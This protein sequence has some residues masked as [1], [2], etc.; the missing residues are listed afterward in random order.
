MVVLTQNNFIA[1]ERLDLEDMTLLLSSSQLDFQFLLNGLMSA[2][3]YIVNGF[4]VASTLGNTNTVQI[5]GASSTLLKANNIGNDPFSFLSL[6]PGTPN[7]TASL[8]ASSRNYVELR[9]TTVQGTP[10]TRNFWDPTANNGLGAEF[11]QEVNTV[12]NLEAVLDIT[13]SGF[14]NDASHIP[15]AIVDTDNTNTIKAIFDARNLFFRLGQFNNEGRNFAWSSQNEPS[16]AVVLSSV[17]GTFVAGE[18]VTFKVGLTTE[19]TATVFSWTP[20]TSTLQIFNLSL[21][22]LSSPIVGDSVTGGT[23][24]ATGTV[25][26]ALDSFTGADKDIANFAE[27]ISALQTEIKAIKG[28]PQWFNVAPASLTSLYNMVVALENFLDGIIVA[29]PADTSVPAPN[30]AWDGAN[31]S[32]TDGSLTPSSAD[33]IA[34]IRVFGVSEVL[35]LARQDGTGGSAVIPVGADQVLFVTLPSPSGNVTYSGVGAGATNYQVVNRTAYVANSQNFWLA[36]SN[37]TTLYVRGYGAIKT[38]Q[39]VQLTEGPTTGGSGTGTGVGDDLGTL[40]YLASFSDL[41]PTP[42]TVAGPINISAGFTNPANYNAAF[43]YWTLNYDASKTLTGTG[44]DMNLSASASYTVVAGDVIRFSNQVRRI[45][46]VISQSHFTIESAFSANPTSAACTVSQAVYTVDIDNYADAGISIQAALGG[47]VNQ[48]LMD[49]DD[50][51]TSGSTVISENVTPFVAYVASSDNSSFSN[52][53]TRT[54]HITDEDTSL[55]LPTTSAG[56]YLRFFANPTSGSGFV[57]LLRYKVFLHSQQP[58]TATGFA[59][60][61]AAFFTD[62]SGTQINCQPPTV[63]GGKTQ[64]QL[65]FTYTPGINSGSENGQLLVTINGQKIPRF[66]SGAT[67]D[68]YYTEVDNET[69]R[70]DSDYS[71]YN[72]NVEVIRWVASVDVN[73]QNQA[74]IALIEASK[75]RNYLINSNF[76]YNQ[77]AGLSGSYSTPTSGAYNLDR[78]N[79]QY[80]GTPGTFSINQPSFTLGQGIVPDEP[81]YYWQLAQTVANSGSTLELLSQKIESVR[82]LANKTV[83]LSFWASADTARTLTIDFRQFFGT[84]GGPSSPVVTPGASFG[85]TTGFQQ[86]SITVSLPSLSGKALGTNGDDYLE[87]RFKTPLNTTKTINISHVMLNEGNGIL[88]WIS[89]GKE[90][91]AELALCQRFY[92]KSWDIDVAVGTGSL[93]TGFSIGLSTPQFGVLGG[94]P[95]V[96]YDEVY[97]VVKRVDAIPHSYSATSGTIDTYRDGSASSDKTATY[98][99]ISQRGFAE[100][101]LSSQNPDSEIYYQWTADAEITS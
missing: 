34:L 40:L 88:P 43:T 11:L 54:V 19:A 36:Y 91:E 31:V 81:T 10:L 84:G 89:A 64:V 63:V 9:L 48:I 41:F 13:T 23:S 29:N 55:A 7:L 80:D 49:Y 44:T 65:G 5:A 98:A 17:V 15:L 32:I 72:F 73:P 3:A 71:A 79:Y 35:S 85:L 82:T 92:E 24:G 75:L 18:T 76:R 16:V 78:W 51:N 14:T 87:V 68:A 56:L 39:T 47:T 8:I 59:L 22:S 33:I 95:T 70:L 77:R 90:A 97:K 74:S 96:G 25:V 83:T 50:N 20:G 100:L 45:T 53:T 101:L 28:T 57:N 60:N 37:G 52:V 61:Q 2:A 21:T 86:Y 99:S 1:S 27:L 26:T 67:P 42:P 62:G 38:G 93:A 12:V 4:E 58:A 69:I 46:A 30:I 6:P 94:K 66:T